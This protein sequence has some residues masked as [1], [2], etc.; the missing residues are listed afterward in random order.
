MTGNCTRWASLSGRE[1]DALECLVA[2]SSNN[3]IG[4]QLYI[5]ETTVRFHVS[6]ILRK[7]GLR[8]R[9]EILRLFPT[10]VDSTP[11]FTDA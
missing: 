7:L 3:E 10:S 6:H 11:E 9:T 4:Q 1:R 8:T 2:G 5:A